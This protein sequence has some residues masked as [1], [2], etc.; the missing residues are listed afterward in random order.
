MSIILNSIPPIITLPKVLTENLTKA[1]QVL[2]ISQSALTRAMQKVEDYI[3]VPIFDRTKNKLMLNDTGKEL[4]KNAQHVIDAEMTMKEKTISFYNQMTNISIGSVAPG[5]MIKYGN[6]L[7]SL[8]PNKTIFSKIEKAENLIENVINGVYDFIFLSY[9][10]EHDFLTCEFVFSESLY[11][12][13]PKTH[14]LSGMKDG[15]HFS[16]IDGQSFLVSNNLGIWDAIV[17]KNLP[18]SKMFPQSMDNLEELINS[19]TIP[20]FSTNT[21][22]SM[23]TNNDRVSIPILD[24]EATVHFYLVYKTQ[25]KQKFRNLLKLMKK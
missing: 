24:D 11:I 13:L 19:S 22:L 9:P 1:S 17:A 18:K 3:G 21:T 8:F 25:N 7:Y 23:R 15:I 5:P 2:H 6:L 20:N 10:I 12:T 16:E 14:F 4:V